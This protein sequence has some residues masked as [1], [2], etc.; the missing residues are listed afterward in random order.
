MQKTQRGMTFLGL[1]I[2]ISFLGIFAYAIIRLVPVYVE[3]MNV[4]KAIDNVKEDV[5]AGVTGE[6]IR[7]GLEKRFQIFDV[8]S[9]EAKDVEI[10]R[11]DNGWTV[12]V[13]YD[14]GAP[15]LGNI[16]LVAHFDKTV[17]LGSAAGGT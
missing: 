12:H 2:L 14:A 16:S 6:G 17:T 4:S 1:L 5:R 7:R 9:I 15:F 3:Y 11:A 10:T 8:S 13:S